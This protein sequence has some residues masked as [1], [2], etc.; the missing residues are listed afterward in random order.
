M[1]SLDHCTFYIQ[2]ENGAKEMA[3]A[4]WNHVLVLINGFEFGDDEKRPKHQKVLC[5]P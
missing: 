1:I 4:E 3:A 5:H 2:T